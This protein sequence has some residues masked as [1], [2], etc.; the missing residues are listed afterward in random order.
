MCNS[1]I[2]FQWSKRQAVLEVTAEGLPIQRWRKIRGFDEA[3][4]LDQDGYLTG[5]EYRNRLN[6]DATARFRWESRVIPFGRMWSQGSS[7]ALTDLTNPNYVQA[8]SDYYSITGQNKASMART[9]T[10]QTSCWGKPVYGLFRWNDYGIGL[11]S[12]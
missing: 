11:G 2:A 12:R 10:I 3:A 8:I 6:K 5:K 4:D 9:M 1:K 7:W